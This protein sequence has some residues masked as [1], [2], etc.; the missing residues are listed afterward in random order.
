M[1]DVDELNVKAFKV[2][3]YD[4]WSIYRLRNDLK[5]VTLRCKEIRNKKLEFFRAF[6]KTA[7][8]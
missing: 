6:F 2:T 1:V 3:C 4:F 5:R 8:S 7:E